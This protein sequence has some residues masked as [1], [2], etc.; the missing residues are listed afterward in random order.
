[1]Y[2]SMCIAAQVIM[3]AVFASK[4]VSAGEVEVLH[5][6]T[7]PG[8][9]KSINE[10]K[11]LISVRGHTWKDF[12]VVG[13]GGDN[14][15]TALNKRILEGN[16]PAAA[17][18][19]GMALQEMASKKVLANL[20]V[21]AQFDHWDKVIPDVVKKHVKYKDNYV[22]VP[23]NIHRANWLWINTDVLKR[24]GIE[25]VPNS[26]EGLLSAA[27]KIKAAGFVP[28]AH[29]GQAWQD[30]L[31]FEGVA[32]GVM[33]VDSYRK[34]F[35]EKDV[36]AIKGSKLPSALQVFRKL[37]AF[38]DDQSK[39]RSWD[40]TTNM[41]IE[42]RAA[43]QMMGDW[44]KG[45]FLIA[46]KRPGIEFLCVPSPGTSDAFTYVIDTFAMFQ[47]KQWEAQKAQGYLAY[48]LMG[49]EFQET[50]SFRKGS[51]P[52]RMDLKLDRFDDC[53]KSSH[54]DFN[55]SSGK[56]RAIP[57]VAVDMALPTVTKSKVQAIVSEFWN[58]DDMAI[59]D[60]AAK[61]ALALSTEGG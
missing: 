29:G 11:R 28:L 16:P 41:V 27:E 36:A 32:M 24:S 43:F 1:M 17:T 61:L 31:L 3:L 57:S 34:V 59:T 52:V 58:K 5:F 6:W 14:A 53:A 19:K 18:I 30:F 42:G 15:M 38:T 56:G 37:K 54:T 9:A 33:G 10:I 44:A 20:D 35:V 12:A 55:A 60:A 45:E 21:M 26:I 23:V 13:G 7:S 46:G 39:N 4:P 50:F 25:K 22:S 2:R 51:I 40:A 8:E 47:L 48:V 49:S